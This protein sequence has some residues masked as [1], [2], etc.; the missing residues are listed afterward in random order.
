MLRISYLSAVLI[1]TAWSSLWGQNLPDLGS[2]YR[3]PEEHYRLDVRYVIESGRFEGSGTIRVK[4]TTQ[5]PLRKLRLSWDGKQPGDLEV[6]LGA[7]PVLLR[8]GAPGPREVELP[9]HLTPER[10]SSSASVSSAPR[11]NWNQERR[12]RLQIGILAYFGAM[13]LTLPS[14]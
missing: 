3:P 13:R 11:R 12:Y 2:P 8:G 10:R 7:K 5:Q 9:A 6:T 1:V 14:T 4:N